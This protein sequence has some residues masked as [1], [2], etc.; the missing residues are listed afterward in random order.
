MRI[1]AIAD[2]HGS[3][4]ARKRVNAQIMEYTPY[5]VVVCGDLTQFGPPEWAEDFLNSIALKTLAIPGNLDPKGVIEAIEN[6]PAIPLHGAKVELEGY[7][8][9]GFGG[10]NPTPMDTPFEVPE[11]E[12]FEA[13]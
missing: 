2:V 12:I 1:L 7:T 11:E 8:F 5:V 3:N 6:S 9:V 10:S 4:E 13:L